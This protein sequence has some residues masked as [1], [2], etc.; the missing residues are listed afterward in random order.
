[1][2]IKQ[3]P[4]EQQASEKVVKLQLN[5]LYNVKQKLIKVFG[6][7]AVSIHAVLTVLNSKMSITFYSSEI[8]RGLFLSEDP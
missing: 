5:R 2:K 3:P 4:A 8:S 1:M 7:A 6:P